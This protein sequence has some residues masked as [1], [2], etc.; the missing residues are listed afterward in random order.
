M[1]LRA[2]ASAYA[3][4]FVV[5]LFFHLPSFATA[6]VT[7]ATL[8]PN[9]FILCHSESEISALQEQYG[10]VLV[11]STP[12]N[13]AMHP[14]WP[15]TLISLLAFS[16]TCLRYLLNRRPD[17]TN[18]HPQPER[19]DQQSDPAIS[20][21][22]P[23][24]S[25]ELSAQPQSAERDRNNGRQN[26]IE[27][28]STAS[29]PATRSKWRRF[30]SRVSASFGI[31][32]LGYAVVSFIT[33][34]IQFVEIQRQKSTGGWLSALACYNLAVFLQTGVLKIFRNPPAYCVLTA[35]SLF[36]IWGGL[37][38]IVQRWKGQVG[39]IAYSVTSLNGCSPSNGLGYLQQ[40][41]RG[42][43]FRIIQT[44]ESACLPFLM[45][46]V[47]MPILWQ[48]GMWREFDEL[49][50]DDSTNDELILEYF[51]RLLDGSK[52]VFAISLLFLYLPVITYE[53]VIAVLG[54]PVVVS[55]N[56]MLVELDPKWG[57]YDAQI[58]SG[59]KVLT[60]I[61]GA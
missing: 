21:E 17:S 1:Y 51:K 40:G 57:F 16:W 23:Q 52:Y 55:G 7:N 10:L 35:V 28:P 9:L 20:P 8:P 34:T 24:Q 11:S 2:V 56:C 27:L 49:V 41:A 61:V 29:V 22:A 19:T 38:V 44:V 59:W 36:T 33:W 39:D 46:A 26:N 58:E 4:I 30:L 5:V 31:M 50:N 43:A 48:S 25:K 45:V 18:Q 14:G 47:E 6:T 60:G 32:V 37:A 53:I 12:T 54:T 15:E 42:R 3:A 13:A